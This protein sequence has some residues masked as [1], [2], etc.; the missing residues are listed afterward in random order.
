MEKRIEEIKTKMNEIEFSIVWMNNSFN[1]SSGKRSKYEKELDRLMA[2]YSDLESELMLYLEPTYSNI[3][4]N[5]GL[6][7]SLLD[8]IDMAKS[9]LRDEDGVAFY[10]P[11]DNPHL[12][13]SNV[14]LRPSW[15]LKKRYRN[16][17][18]VIWYNTS[19][20]ELDE[21]SHTDNSFENIDEEF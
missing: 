6:V 10:V 1:E 9:G 15:C 12:E 11:D 17:S 4:E 18:R 16:I 14:Y 5:Y 19:E 2:E 3:D 7:V 21:L 8:F 13:T 20:I